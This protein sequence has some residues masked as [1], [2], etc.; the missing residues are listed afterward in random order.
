MSK[1]PNAS[2]PGKREA[3]ADIREALFNEVRL[4]LSNPSKFPPSGS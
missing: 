2:L 1:I 4:G 3:E